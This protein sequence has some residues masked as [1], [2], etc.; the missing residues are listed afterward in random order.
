MEAASEQPT[1]YC[2][3]TSKATF[4]TRGNDMTSDYKRLNSSMTCV[5]IALH[6][7]Y[8]K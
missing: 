2:G 3:L 1:G 7:I 5:N 8:K 6:N 4:K